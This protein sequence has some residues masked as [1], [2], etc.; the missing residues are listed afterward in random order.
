MIVRATLP[1]STAPISI[2]ES[3]SG[4]G[5]LNVFDAFLLPKREPRT[6]LGSGRSLVFGG[7]NVQFPKGER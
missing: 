6:N 4:R 2:V 1:V 3:V 7:I 5:D